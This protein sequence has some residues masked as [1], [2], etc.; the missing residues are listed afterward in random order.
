MTLA[1]MKV[2]LAALEAQ[3]DEIQSYTINGSHSVTKVAQK[4]IGVQ[5]ALLRRRIFRF[6]GYTGRTYPEFN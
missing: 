6:Q 5:I 4:D 1:E 3:R 2:K